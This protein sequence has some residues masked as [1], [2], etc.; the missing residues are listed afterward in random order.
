MM[1][2]TTPGFDAPGTERSDASGSERPLRNIIA[3]L[4]ENTEKLVRQEMELASAEL[5]QKAERLKRDLL[6]ATIGGSVA[7][8][9]LLALVAAL[10]LLLAQGIAAWLSALIVGAVVSSIGYA[11]LQR[12]KK[13]MQPKHTI[14]EQTISSVQRTAYAFKEA[15]K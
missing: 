15:A 3:E 2:E 9:G 14:P 6:L 11:L 12:G 4:W 5:D 10:I 8:A 1:G 7:Y 13:A